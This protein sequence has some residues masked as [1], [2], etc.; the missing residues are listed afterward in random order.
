MAVMA[1]GQG[2]AVTAL[3]LITLLLVVVCSTLLMM[4]MLTS[5]QC[6]GHHRATSHCTT[7][8]SSLSR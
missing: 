4:M 8:P 2:D 3:V 6:T 1:S 7:S 5:V